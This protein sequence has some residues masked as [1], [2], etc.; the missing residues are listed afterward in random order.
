[1]GSQRIGLSVG[2]TRAEWS[3]IAIAV[4]WREA[5]VVARA[6]K[7]AGLRVGVHALSFYVRGDECGYRPVAEYRTFGCSPR[8]VAS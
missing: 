1:M 8:A 6:F 5:L 2:V 7:R 4:G 3:P